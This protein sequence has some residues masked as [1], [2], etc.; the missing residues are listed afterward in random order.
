MS[1]CGFFLWW[2]RGQHQQWLNIASEVTCQ[3]SC[4]WRAKI[5]NV[6][7]GSTEISFADSIKQDGL[8]LTGALRTETAEEAT[9]LRYTVAA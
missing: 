4:A 7:L 3:Q 2:L 5:H 6:R 1:V 8:I 9:T